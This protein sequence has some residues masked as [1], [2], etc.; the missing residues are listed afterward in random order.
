MQ[1]NNDIVLNLLNIQYNLYD[2]VYITRIQ[3]ERLKE[4]EY[5]KNNFIFTNNDA[6]KMKYNS[7]IMHPFPRNEELSTDV[8]KNPRAYYFKQIKYGIELRMAIL[9]LTLSFNKNF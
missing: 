4:N 6:N 9:Y 7:I 8:D 3:K 1:S 2:I 5:I